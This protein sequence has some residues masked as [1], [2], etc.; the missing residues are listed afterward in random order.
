MSTAWFTK[1]PGSDVAVGSED[2]SMLLI[3]SGHPD[4]V[5]LPAELGGH[6]VRVES[7]GVGPC[8]CGDDHDARHY[9]LE[10]GICVAE[11]CGKF[12]WY[13]ERTP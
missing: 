3:G 6:R 4:W 2:P 12:L 7:V 10:G 5:R 13:R 11:C 9:R 8:A 1:T